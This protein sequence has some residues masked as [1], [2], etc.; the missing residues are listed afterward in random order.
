MATKNESFVVVS[1]GWGEDYAVP[2]S[3]VSD[4][5]VMFEKFQPVKTGYRDNED[6]C[7]KVPARRMALR[8]YPQILEEEPPKE[9]AAEAA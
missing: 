4:L 1:F 2:S 8:M 7:W 9:E 3:M 5:L 6:I